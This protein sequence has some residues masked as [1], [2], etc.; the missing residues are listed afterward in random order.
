LRT[1]Y[2]T[3]RVAPDAPDEVIRAAYRAL[4][5][6]HHPDRNPGDAGATRLMQALNDAYAVLSDPERRREHDAWIARDQAA[7]AAS[8]RAFQAATTPVASDSTVR[9]DQAPPA[10]TVRAWHGAL[11]AVLLM[12][13]GASAV[14]LL[15]HPRAPAPAVAPRVEPIDGWSVRGLESDPAQAR[16]R[17]AVRA[18]A[19]R[20][21]PPAVAPGGGAWRSG[22]GVVRGGTP[23]P[24]GSRRTIRATGYDSARATESATSERTVSKWLGVSASST[25]G[26]R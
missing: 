26:S 4:T 17:R 18:A 12:L 21:A 22:V 9:A 2:D 20:L 7:R 1:H 16:A 15:W 8:L 14:A 13:L 3:L 6:R 10:R 24:S 11:I 23:A 19:A 25:A 5:Q